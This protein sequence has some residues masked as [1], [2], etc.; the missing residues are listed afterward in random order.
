MI[1]EL[2]RKEDKEEVLE[3]GEEIRRFWKVGVD[4]D[5]TMEERKRRWRMMEIA[6]R[7]RAKGRRVEMSNRVENGEQEMDLD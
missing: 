3:K 1:M 5:L 4:E 7:E 6:R 2:E